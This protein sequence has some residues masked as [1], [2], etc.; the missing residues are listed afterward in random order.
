MIAASPCPATFTFAG[1]VDR[2]DRRVGSGVFRPARHV[3]ARPSLKCASTLSCCSSPGFSDQRSAAEFQSSRSADHQPS[4]RACPAAIQ[5]RQHRVFRR[6]DLEPLAALMRDGHRRLEQQQASL[7]MGVVD[8]A[9]HGIA[10][11]GA[12]VA[13]VVVAAKRELEA[14]LP[15]RRPVARAAAASGGHQ[16]RLNIIAKTGHV[17]GASAAGVSA[18]SSQWQL[19][20]G[21]GSQRDNKAPNFHDS[22]ALASFL[23][24]RFTAVLSMSDGKSEIVEFANDVQRG[25]GVLAPPFHVRAPTQ[26]LRSIQVSAVAEYAHPTDIRTIP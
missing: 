6:L 4:A 12:P 9:A 5:S 10:G 16:D 24:T 25:V 15:R 13:F 7:G 1:I 22:D 26:R 8:S 20:R 3:A 2:R 23:A 19:S 11:E 17:C 21:S 18:R 14:I